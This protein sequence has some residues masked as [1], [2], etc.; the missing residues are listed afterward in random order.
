MKSGGNKK[1]HKRAELKEI[2]VVVTPPE[3]PRVITPPAS[4]AE[5]PNKP[6]YVKAVSES[7]GVVER[8]TDT[9]P[10]G[11]TVKLDV[12][13]EY[14]PPPPNCADDD[15]EQQSTKSRTIR[16]RERGSNKNVREGEL[17]M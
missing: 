8:P 1:E 4:V 11:A 10:V 13:N 15:L 12:L 14:A 3:E 6:E 9:G 17:T 5:V 2:D 16:V 7:D